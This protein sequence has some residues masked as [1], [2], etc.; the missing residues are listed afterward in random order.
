[1]QYELD[2]RTPMMPNFLT[3]HRGSVQTQMPVAD[4]TDEQ[5]AALW[6]TWKAEWLAHVQRKRTVPKVT[7]RGE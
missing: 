7:Y 5:A 3:I 2:I 4:L 6:D 1:M